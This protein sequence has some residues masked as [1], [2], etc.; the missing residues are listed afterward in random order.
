MNERIP[1]Q[2]FTE[3]ERELAEAL[4]ANGPEYPETKEKL[5]EWLAGKESWG[6]K[7]KNNRAKIEGGI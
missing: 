5:L 2:E 7:Q 6:K 4:R 3:K 1:G